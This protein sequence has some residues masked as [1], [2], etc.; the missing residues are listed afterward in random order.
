MNAA[1]T[2]I[3]DAIAKLQLSDTDNMGK[4]SWR[5]AQLFVLV[6]I[7]QPD[8]QEKYFEAV[9][10]ASLQILKT[11]STFSLS[12]DEIISMIGNH[13]WLKSEKLAKNSFIK[14]LKEIMLGITQKK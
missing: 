8:F 7:S 14:S 4:K 2:D 5:L 10:K 3:K 6:Y 13:T 11:D 12:N 9:Y 1:G